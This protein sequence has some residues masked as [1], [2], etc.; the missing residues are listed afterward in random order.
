MR[1]V[2]AVRDFVHALRLGDF[3]Q[4]LRTTAMK[5]RC[6]S[7]SVCDVLCATC[8]GPARESDEGTLPAVCAVLGCGRQALLRQ[9]HLA[10]IHACTQFRPCH[11]YLPSALRD[12]CMASQKG[13]GTQ[14]C[15]TGLFALVARAFCLILC[16]GSTGCHCSTEASGH[17]HVRNRSE[18]V[19]NKGC[20]PVRESGRDWRYQ[21]ST[22]AWMRLPLCKTSCFR[23]LRMDRM[24]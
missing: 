7:C 17:N 24:C 15:W 8:T 10:D 4:D 9:R 22:M 1:G 3:V 21:I 5:V 18:G 11:K 20:E 2:G 13:C 12:E 14:G 23:L 6:L 19:V 16:A